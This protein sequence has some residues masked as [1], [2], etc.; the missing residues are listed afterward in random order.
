LVAQVELGMPDR[1]HLFA[2]PDEATGDRG[3]NHAV[4]PGNPDSSAAHAPFTDR[5]DDRIKT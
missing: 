2:A 3:S 5:T 1:E 4:V